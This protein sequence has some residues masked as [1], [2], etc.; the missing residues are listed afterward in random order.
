VT[1]RLVLLTVML[2]LATGVC[3][4]VR[5]SAEEADDFRSV[6]ERAER[7][8]REGKLDEAIQLEEALLETHRE[9]PNLLWNLGIMY[10]DTDRH[11]KALESW[12]TL[13]RLEPDNWRVRAKLIQTHQAR[14][15]FEQRDRE[16][17]ALYQARRESSDRALSREA[18]YCR[19]QFRVAGRK[20]MVFEYFEPA[21]DRQVF[22][23]FSILSADGSEV[24]WYSLGSYE[25]TTRAARAHGTIGQDQRIF[26]IDRYATNRYGISHGAVALYGY[27]PAYDVVRSRVIDALLL[28]KTPAP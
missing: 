27:L 7:L 22:L 25:F 9:D 11:A 4:V 18:M 10:A 6:F 24:F 15:D 21:G 12:Q 23:R 19:E 17:E 16:R 8:A 5:C 20:V 13:R 3:C 26:H 14:A 28:E 1:R 2:A